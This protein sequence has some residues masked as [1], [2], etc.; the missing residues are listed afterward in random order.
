MEN[1]DMT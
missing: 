1:L